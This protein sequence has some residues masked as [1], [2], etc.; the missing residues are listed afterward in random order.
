VG[1]VA[2]QGI[3]TKDGS[4]IEDDLVVVGVGAPQREELARDAGL[5]VGNGIV[6]AEFLHTSAA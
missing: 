6:V 1:T 2:A 5:H 4:L 3:R